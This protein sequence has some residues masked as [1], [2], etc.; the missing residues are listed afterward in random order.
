M[1]N[2][3]L[4]QGLTTPTPHRQ[5]FFF[6]LG[7]LYLFVWDNLPWVE[8]QR[9]TGVRSPTIQI[10]L[11]HKHGQNKVSGCFLSPPP[12]PLKLATWNIFHFFCSLCCSCFHWALH[13]SALQGS[14]AHAPF[15]DTKGRIAWPASFWGCLSCPGRLSRSTGISWPVPMGRE[16]LEAGV[17]GSYWWPCLAG[18]QWSQHGHIWNTLIFQESLRITVIKCKPAC[19]HV[20]ILL[21]WSV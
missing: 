7:I 15:G 4:F 2:S 20:Q 21:A 8:E 16:G 12:S 6:A 18:A 13:T 17:T 11:S 19:G 5:P 1:S 14:N 9:G 3:I 10:I